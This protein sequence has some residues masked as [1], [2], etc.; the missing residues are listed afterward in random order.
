MSEYS[1]HAHQDTNLITAINPLFSPE[2]IYSLREMQTK[3]VINS[4]VISGI[5]NHPEFL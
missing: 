3:A 4:L 5:Q 2:A 1:I